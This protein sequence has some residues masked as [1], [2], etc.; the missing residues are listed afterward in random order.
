MFIVQCTLIFTGQCDTTLIIGSVISNAQM[1]EHTV[2]CKQILLL[3]K[4]LA[5]D[6]GKSIL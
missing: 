4:I 1:F 3:Q 5:L 2:F 6:C